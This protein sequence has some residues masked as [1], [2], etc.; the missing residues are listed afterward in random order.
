MRKLLKYLDGYKKECVLAP[1]FKM[2]EAVFELT[3]P[4]VISHMIDSGIGNGAAPVIRNCFL[5]LLALGLLGLIVSCTAQF[6]AA[7]AA[8][9]FS[10][11]LRHDL[12]EHIL[13]FGFPQIDRCTTSTM[14]TR[15]TVDVNVLQNGVNMFLRLFL[16]SPFIVAGAMIMAFTID[17]KSAMIFVLVIAALA[18]TVTVI[19]RTNIPL[20]KKAQ[21]KLDELLRLV[22]ENLSGARVIRAFTLEDE[23][24]ADFKTANDELT[25]MQLLAG[26]IS[27][28]LNPLTYV[29]VNLGIVALIFTGSRQVSIGALS[30]GAV[31]ALYNYMSQIL[32]ELIKF[33]NLIVTMNR[34]FASAIRVNEMFEVT[35]D[36]F[37]T[38]VA[39]PDNE[40]DAP[41]AEFSD[42]SLKYHEN[43]DDAI[44]NISFKIMKGQTFG[45]IGGTGAGKSTVAHILSGFYKATGG[46]VLISGKDINDIDRK[47]LG[48]HVGIVMQSAVLFAGTI[49][50][51]LRWGNP[52]AT[53][54]EIMDAVK[55]AVC[56][57]VVEE[58][59]GLDAIIEAGGKN[60]S[61]GQR[62]RLSI[63]RV[64]VG[65][66]EILILDDSASAL[67]YMTDL[68]LRNNI[69]ELSYHPTVII[70][71]QRTVSVSGCENILVLDDGE[72]A[73]LGTHEELLKSSDVYREIYESQYGK[74]EG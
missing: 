17:V 61:G 39:A 26:R 3:V 4:L 6:F 56:T 37:S 25:G 65:K 62:Q 68:K 66:P 24:I 42:V 57:E 29:L 9:G 21:K 28:L 51:N 27:S 19:M 22:R 71:A 1:L 30:T 59:G 12:F 32:L 16:R 73:G 53:D 23:Q 11:G 14:I 40:G 38:A 52:S 50:E 43:A 48:K 36:D 2:L 20:L 8:T 34:T 54:E 72:M 49:R 44:S 74:E 67:D 60:L 69:A 31:V 70:I 47:L 64:L 45:I 7:K 46:K 15:M 5:I 58:K 41:A 18:V 10:K 55:T 63:A 35:A 13:S 33:A